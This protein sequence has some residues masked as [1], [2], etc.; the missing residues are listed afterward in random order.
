MKKRLIHGVLSFVV[1]VSMLTVPQAAIFA[2]SNSQEEGT[3]Q[4]EQ[5]KSEGIQQTFGAIN[6][7]AAGSAQAAD[8][9]G[10]STQ[11]KG[12]QEAGEQSADGKDAG[13]Q[14]QSTS[15]AS[16]AQQ[17]SSTSQPSNAKLA[18]PSTQQKSP[19]QESTN[20]ESTEQAQQK[21]P[22]KA[23]KDGAVGIGEGRY[24]SLADALTEAKDGDVIKL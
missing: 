16:N 7:A 23:T 2:T 8:E 12:T 9:Q 14:E 4:I 6:Q 11:D 21:P 5:S 1:A 19:N 10:I 22:T 20:Q 24:A 3:S 13:Q 17:Q 15:Q 18:A